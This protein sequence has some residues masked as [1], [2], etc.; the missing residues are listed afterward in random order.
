MTQLQPPSPNGSP[1]GGLVPP[2]QSCGLGFVDNPD[3][4]GVHIAVALVLGMPNGQLAGALM[5]GFARE[6]G[7][8]MIDH[9][10]QCTALTV[11]SELPPEMKP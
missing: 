1:E 4:P 5:P 7:Q 6:L 11:A 9:A 3:A 10:D 2:W 8:A